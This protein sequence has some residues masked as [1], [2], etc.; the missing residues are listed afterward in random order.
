M[1]KNKS[2]TEMTNENDFQSEKQNIKNHTKRRGRLL[3]SGANFWDFTTDPE[4]IGYYLGT[5][6]TDPRETNESAGIEKG[7]V[8]G[9]GFVD[10]QG[11][12]WNIGASHS[13]NKALEMINEETGEAEIQVDTLV[14]IR[15]K[16]LKELKG[17]KSVNQYDVE[18]LD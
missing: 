6:I 2:N 16:G 17:G 9:Y 18:I 15:W 4:F 11:E 13:I 14:L 3:V 8:L 7:R 1:A 10:E 5:K 12:E